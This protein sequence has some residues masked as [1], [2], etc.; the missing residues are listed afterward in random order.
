MYAKSEDEL[1]KDCEAITMRK[2]KNPK[3]VQRFLKF[4]QRREE[5]LTI[6]RFNT[7]TRNN[8]TNNLCEAAIRIIKEIVLSRT[9]AYN[10][11]ALVDFIVH[12]FNKYL[13]TRLL[14]KAYNRVCD[15]NL[16]E[17]LISKMEGVKSENISK[18]DESTYLVPSSTVD[19]IRYIV[20]V[21]IGY[22]ICV[23]GKIGAFYKQQC[24]L[25]HCLKIHL[26]N[27]P[28]L[29]SIDRCTLAGIALGEQCPPQSFFGEFSPKVKFIGENSPN[30]PNLV[31]SENFHR[32]FSD[33]L[34]NH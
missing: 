26:P 3:Y 27:A 22:C 12:K 1:K 13:V 21:D 30:S 14:K 8:N 33:F 18:I 10:I 7:I 6:D 5:W 11:M 28:A 20:N 31:N 25:M 29:N 4:L 15:D 23:T 24:F 16:Y 19:N 17:D 9:K 32:K 2:A 34:E